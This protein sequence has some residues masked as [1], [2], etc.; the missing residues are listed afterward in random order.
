VQP[1]PPS[2][3]VFDASAALAIISHEPGETLARRF[4]GAAAIST[5]NYAE[6]IGRLVADGLAE[7][8]AVRAVD[9]LGLEVAPFTIEQARAAGFLRATTRALGLSLGDRSCLALAL[10]RQLPVLT[11]DRQWSALRLPLQVIL[12][13]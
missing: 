7:P 5:V 1:Q 6:V 4:L 8:N 12:I 10:E 11:A 9:R 3:I 2:R 13:R